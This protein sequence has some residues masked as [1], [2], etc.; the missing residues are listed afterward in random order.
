MKFRRT[1][2]ASLYEEV[3]GNALY[4]PENIVSPRNL[5]IHE[6]TNMV[7]ELTNPYSNLF[8]NAVRSVPL[9]YLCGELYWYFTG[10]NS[11]EFIRKYSKF[12]DGIANHDRTIN[13]AYGWMLFERNSH[14]MSE[15]KWAFNSL[16]HDVDSR[17]AI[18][19]F[20]VPEHMV[21]STKDFP[22]T[23][24]A[25]FQIR[26]DK[27]NLTVVMRSQDIIKGL[28]FD[29]PFFTLLQQNMHLLLHRKY[30]L[31]KLGTLTLFVESMH[32]YETDFELG[33]KMMIEK[34]VPAALPSMVYPLYDNKF[35]SLKYVNNAEPDE[36]IKFILKH[37]EII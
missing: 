11:L 24:T 31:L 19:H 34:F 28:T 23:L 33:K 1:T 27:L 37:G 35:Y 7:L 10:S 4:H 20:N 6:V 30:K 17:Q 25:T 14:K 2:F 21:K 12:W 9:K 13:S 3:L 18:M 26:H 22:C 5:K 16:W 36:L 32:I 29:L 8:E 15:W